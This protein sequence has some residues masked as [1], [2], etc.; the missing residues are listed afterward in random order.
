MNPRGMARAQ[1]AQGL[2]RDGGLSQSVAADRYFDFIV[3]AS[4]FF[5]A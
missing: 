2:G 4:R 1:R 3:P 5:S